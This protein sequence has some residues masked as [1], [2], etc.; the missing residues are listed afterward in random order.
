M[1][2]IPGSGRYPGEGNGNSLHI[3]AWKIPWTEDPGGL[4][5]MGLQSGTRLSTHTLNPSPKELSL[6]E[7]PDSTAAPA[8]ELCKYVL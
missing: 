3:L 7:E 2:S 8:K 1:G 5:S 6:T 4:Q